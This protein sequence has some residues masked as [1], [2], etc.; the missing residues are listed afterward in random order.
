MKCIGGVKRNKSGY[1]GDRG[2]SSK[3][4]D[5]AIEHF[6]I[7]ARDRSKSFP[8]LASCENI[9]GKYFPFEDILNRPCTMAIEN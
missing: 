2:E 9:C 4:G 6:L 5:R 3:K 8:F 7:P 1:S